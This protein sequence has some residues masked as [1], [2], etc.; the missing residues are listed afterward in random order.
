M[1]L[2]RH[3][4]LPLLFSLLLSCTHSPKSEIAKAQELSSTDICLE[5]SPSSEKIR[6]ERV[7]AEPLPTDAL[8]AK[9]I[10]S[11]KP[12]DEPTLSYESVR[13]QRLQK[14]KISLDEAL[15][16]I[17]PKRPLAKP[18]ANRIADFLILAHPNLNKAQIVTKLESNNSL[19]GALKNKLTTQKNIYELSTS[20]VLQIAENNLAP[21]GQVLLVEAHLRLNTI[22]NAPSQSIQ[23]L[24]EILIQNGYGNLLRDYINTDFSKIAGKGRNRVRFV[25]EYYDSITKFDAQTSDR[26]AGIG[27]LLANNVING[28]VPMVLKDL[29]V[30][31]TLSPITEA[32]ISTAIANKILT[33]AL[34]IQTA[35]EIRVDIAHPE[36]AKSVVLQV[37]SQPGKSPSHTLAAVDQWWTQQLEATGNVNEA[38]IALRASKPLRL[39]Q[40]N[41]EPSQ[42]LNPYILLLTKA[43]SDSV[44]RLVL[45]ELLQMGPAG[46]AKY[47]GNDTSSPARLDA[48]L[49]TRP[50]SPLADQALSEFIK[51][52]YRQNLSG[53]ELNPHL[54]KLKSN[55]EKRYPD[56][57][58]QEADNVASLLKAHE[59]DQIES[60]RD[61]VLK[62]QDAVEGGLQRALDSVIQAN[63]PPEL[64]RTQK[65]PW[66]SY[67]QSLPVQIRSEHLWQILQKNSRNLEQTV[68]LISQLEPIDGVRETLVRFLN[69][70][71]PGG[72][73]LTYFS[74]EQIVQMFGR[75]NRFLRFFPHLNGSKT[76]ELTITAFAIAIRTDPSLG[77]I[78]GLDPRWLRDQA[79]NLSNRNALPQAFGF[80]PAFQYTRLEAQLQEGFAG[81][82]YAMPAQQIRG[83]IVQ[84]HYEK[85]GHSIMEP[86]NNG[87][88]QAQLEDL[89]PS[90][91]RKTEI[92][93]EGKGKALEQQPPLIQRLFTVNWS[94]NTNGSLINNIRNRAIVIAE[95]D[96]RFW[97]LRVEIHNF[98]THDTLRRVIEYH[99]TMANQPMA[100]EMNTLIRE[101]RQFLGE[102]NGEGNLASVIRDRLEVPDKNRAT[103]MESVA[104]FE[105]QTLTVQLER[106]DS[107]RAQ[108]NEILGNPS[109]GR[110]RQFLLGDQ[111]LSE[112]ATVI[113]SKWLD[114]LETRPFSERIDGITLGLKHL[115]KD[116]VLSESQATGYR[117]A[118]DNIARTS[119]LPEIEKK[120]MV[121][122]VL[123]G[124]VDQVYFRAQ[125]EFGFYDNA[126]FRAT[127]SETKVPLKFIDNFMRSGMIFMLSK[128]I[129]AQAREIAVAKNI[130]H[131][132]HDRQV[133][134][135]VEVYNPGE[136]VGVLRLNKDPMALGRDDIAVFEQMP[137][138]SAAVSGFITVGV[139]AR[140]S[141]LQLLSKSLKIPNV[142]IAR[143]L[144][145][146]LRALDGKWVRFRADENGR[147][148]L[149]EASREN[150]LP[151]NKNQ[152]QVPL[153]N[154]SVRDPIEF[155]RLKDNPSA[156]Y[157]G[158]K[159][160]TLAKLFQNQA[161]RDHVPDGVVLPFGFFREYSE[162]TGLQP[163]L[164]LLGQ[165]RLENRYLIG[166]LTSQIALKI[167]KTPLPHELLEKAKA[168][169]AAL[170]ERTGNK[171]G[172]FFRSDTNVE[173]L[174]NFNGAGLNES[175]PNVRND[176]SA[177]DSAIRRVWISPYT[178]KS[179]Y[180][181]GEALGSPN[182]TIA[183]PSVVIM[184]T[185]QAHS[186]GVLIS[187]GG[188]DWKPG[189]G[190]TS[191]NF[192]I[193][194]VV[195]AGRPVEEYTFELGYPL[196]TSMSVSRTMPVA[197]QSGGLKQVNIQPGT[198]VLT[199]KQP[200]ELNQMGQK[201]EKALGDEPHGWDIEWAFDSSGRFVILQA[202]PNM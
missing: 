32:F 34:L 201:I 59:F 126:M 23:H 46:A 104:D 135:I 170:E 175:V 117:E 99:Q 182:V 106:L 79:D 141:H 144:L 162:K 164:D 70:Y 51:G 24:H 68:R 2:L 93:L 73:R 91:Q 3:Y 102:T 39:Q 76:N 196:R 65:N 94:L 137:G 16:L 192:G 60:I 47:V 58:Q 199:G 139:G 7:F 90:I 74:Q 98:P 31:P 75:E 86:L 55:L 96:R 56:L 6:C 131:T 15:N 66:H 17:A 133:Q 57:R 200:L 198:P 153:A 152:I 84:G 150:R 67:L 109:F 83:L 195:E 190:R 28:N 81:P 43:N 120:E 11:E 97:D 21:E 42:W 184:P 35:R 38:L 40:M 165:V 45:D 80:R 156:Q 173:D 127:A 179:I 9:R 53:V 1:K 20:E 169:I 89:A 121:N 18:D 110:R 119:H 180:W 171:L 122:L 172:Y 123:K 87:R 177:I 71:S 186:S 85:I 8:Q 129:D 159:G 13:L 142:Q 52:Y 197:D 202:R 154:H 194:S 77:V 145:P 10:G 140:L 64:F 108:W 163:L 29:L 4:P 181:R 111:A 178:E 134:G 36:I 189:R 25:G 143:D 78:G 183:E 101:L 155:S 62:N 158:P 50:L 100:S 193:G 41:A 54:R 5:R 49:E 72:D 19:W 33:P 136:T 124:L 157:A 115:V 174:P 112:T 103:M 187:R 107:L 188:M 168:S 138:E 14:L 63:A 113:F 176:A 105:N 30:D 148:S 130:S 69:S 166:V 22:K 48:L 37:L 149:E 118:L 128:V 26:N 147:L 44:R 27:K 88:G 95:S 191:A 82:H 185:I 116:D 167:E 61:F 12:P 92:Q 132:I 161:L 160:V 146:E 114:T 151:Q 125:D